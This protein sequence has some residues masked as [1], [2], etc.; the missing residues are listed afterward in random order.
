MAYEFTG[1][2]EVR[3]DDR[4]RIPIPSK[5]LEGFRKFAL[6]KSE[7]GNPKAEVKVIVGMSL[8]LQPT[9]FPKPVFDELIAYLESKPKHNPKWQ[10]VKKTIIG[11]AEEQTIDAQ[12]RIRVSRVLAKH[13]NLTGEIVIMNA[14]NQLELHN[15]ETFATS[16]DE[17]KG[18]VNELTE[19]MND[20]D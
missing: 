17:L 4:L 6:P 10:K 14:G 15:A 9:I 13:F 3:T 1:N 18:L 8:E 12:G 11:M 19:E 2:Q 20:D 7:W 5:M 16:L